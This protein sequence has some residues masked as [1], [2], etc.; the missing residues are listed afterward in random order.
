VSISV[1][2]EDAKPRLKLLGVRA[3]ALVELGDSEA[4][5]LFLRE[6]DARGRTGRAGLVGELKRERVVPEWPDATEHDPGVVLVEL[7]AYAG[8]LLSYYQD[9]VVNESR[10]RPRRFA[11]STLAVV[12]LLWCWRRHRPDDR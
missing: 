9:R 11:I 8:D 1:T 7:L 2:L 10:L 3:F 4:I 12:A 5:D 6:E